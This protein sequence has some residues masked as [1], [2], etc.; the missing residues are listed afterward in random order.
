M[1]LPLTI[2]VTMILNRQLYRT[3]EVVYVQR[4]IVDFT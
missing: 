4:K 3:Y 2:L 1:Q